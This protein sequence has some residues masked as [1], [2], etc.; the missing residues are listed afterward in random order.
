MTRL[1]LLGTNS[2]KETRTYCKKCKQYTHHELSRNSKNNIKKLDCL[3]CKSLKKKKQ[4]GV[5]KTKPKG[6]WS[7]PNSIL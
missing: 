4:Y 2:N 5:A 1:K 7:K 3:Y 6:G